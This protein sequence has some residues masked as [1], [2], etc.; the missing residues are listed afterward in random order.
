M[1]HFE[2]AQ[3]LINAGARTDLQNYNEDT[4]KTWAMA[5][6]FD[7]IDELIPTVECYQVAEEYVD[8]NK[9]ANL[10]PT[11]LQT[12]QPP[13]F[14]DVYNMLRSMETELYM[15]NFV[16][17]KVNLMEFLTLTDA[18]LIEI[19]VTYPVARN[20]ILYGIHK[21][22]RQKWS[23]L[24]LPL[25]AKQN[26]MI[27]VLSLLSGYLKQILV[28]QSVLT[29]VLRNNFDRDD[30]TIRQLLTIRAQFNEIAKKL[31]IL[32]KQIRNVRF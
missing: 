12:E 22:H 4:P 32:Q 24:T 23:P 15:E 28:V 16:Q 14:P 9:L 20:R 8:Y 29:F 17:N 30:K 31:P 3:A 5:N 11:V 13:F 18:R 19:G 21:F 6:G 10:I 7:R 1:K 25:L 27:D 2:I 26:S